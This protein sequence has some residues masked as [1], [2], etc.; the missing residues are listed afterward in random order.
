MT[1]KTRRPKSPDEWDWS[2]TSD[3]IPEQPYFG[4]DY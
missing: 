2:E 1:N 4:A 3:C